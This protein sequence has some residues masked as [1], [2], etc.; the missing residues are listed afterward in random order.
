V[1]S[2]HLLRNNVAWDNRTHG[3]SDDQGAD[4]G[5]QMINNTAY[6]NGEDGFGV[7]EMPGVL[8]D[9]VSIENRDHQVLASDGARQSGNSWQRGGWSAASFR[10]TDPSSAIGPRRPDGSLPRTDFLRTG[11][12]V[13]AVLSE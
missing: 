11:D 8:R 12:G 1:A 13:G 6:R 4:A 10:S 5:T 7:G 2:A 9:N 3:F